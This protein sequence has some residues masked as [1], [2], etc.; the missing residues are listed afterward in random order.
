MFPFNIPCYYYL[1]LLLAA[2]HDASCILT[3]RPARGRIARGPLDIL[4]CRGLADERDG[5]LPAQPLADA[6]TLRADGPLPPRSQQQQGAYKG[7]PDRDAAL[8]PC[9]VRLLP[10][11]IK[12]NVLR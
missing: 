1:A 7:N 8:G 4:Q 12:F 6:G 10:R 11:T 3:P 9:A 5:A 2:A